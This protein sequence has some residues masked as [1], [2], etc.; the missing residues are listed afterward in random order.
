M[1]FKQDCLSQCHQSGGNIPLPLPQKGNGQNNVADGK[2]QGNG[3]E[4]CHVLTNPTYTYIGDDTTMQVNNLNHGMVHRLTTQI[5]YTL[6]V[7]SVITKGTMM[8]LK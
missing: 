4:V 5:P 2:L 6:S 3:C 8:C 1:S 7:T